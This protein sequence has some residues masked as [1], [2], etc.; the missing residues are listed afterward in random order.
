MT[1]LLK[2]SEFNNLLARKIKPDCFVQMAVA[3]WGI[4]AMKNL[5]L[6]G[7]KNAQLI[8]NLTTG[9]TNPYEI[10]AM[11]A[12]GI[13]VQMH[14]RLHAK[15][16]IIGND[17]S[18]VGSSNMSANGLGFEGEELTG[19][20]EANSITE[21][22]DPSIRARFEELWNQSSKITDD[23]LEQ[24]KHNWA[25]RRI[26]AISQSP[27]KQKE[28]KSLWEA[29]E[30]R[31]EALMSIPCHVAY[32]YEMKD[33]ELEYFNE[34]QTEI[35]GELGKNCIVYQDWEELP[36]GYIIGVCR[37]R[38]RADTLKDIDCSR[39]SPNTPTYEKE[40]SRYSALTKENA[41]P[42]FMALSG[43]DLKQFKAL[44]LDYIDTKKKLKKSRVISIQTLMDFARHR[45]I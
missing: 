25:S 9:G 13:Q 16:G 30:E 2:G 44:V 15:I 26:F 28:A 42:G 21:G 45:R 17:I 4:G 19:W 43:D 14:N 32:Y 6:K 18:F 31:S 27:K 39:R 11:I 40:G 20:E 5:K 7:N 8:C 38:K 37:S 36:E 34:V 41:V 35:K 10:E 1:K 33:K 23:D 22:I 12:S 29:I 3:F 24:A